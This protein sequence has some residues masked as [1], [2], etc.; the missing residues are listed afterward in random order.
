[1]VCLFVTLDPNILHQ[2]VNNHEAISETD[3]LTNACA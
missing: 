2:G 3:K 1:M